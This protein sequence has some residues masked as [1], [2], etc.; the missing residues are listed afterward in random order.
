MIP[1]L[2][3]SLEAEIEGYRRR[4]DRVVEALSPLTEISHPGGA[5][6]CFFKVPEHL[7]ITGAAF[8]E[9]AVEH[10]VLLVAGGVFSGRDTHVRLSFA[11]P[12]DVLEE[13]LAVLQS[14]LAGT[15]AS[16]S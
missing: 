15:S 2:E 8:V 14:M 10:R 5:F 16:R 11:V 1:S 12:E 4:R 7:G 3:L 9:K 6:Y 13:G